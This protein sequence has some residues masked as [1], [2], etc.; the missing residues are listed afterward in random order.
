ME[1]YSLDLRQR[2][3][4]ACDEAIETRPEMAQAFS[5]S[6]SFVNKL[7]RRWK[8]TGSAAARPKGKGPPPVLDSPKLEQ[9]RQCVGRRPDSTLGE[10]CGAL[11]E[12]GGP[13]VSRSTICR[14][15]RRLGLPLKK[16][17]YTPASGIRRA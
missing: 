3:V 6:L 2:I 8:D 1:A 17:L 16:S 5:V 13:A 15:L 14:G 10:L 9:L 12:V 11:V 4:R 7:W